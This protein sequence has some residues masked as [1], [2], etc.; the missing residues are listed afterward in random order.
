MEHALSESGHTQK[1]SK[2]T[3]NPVA[4]GPKSAAETPSRPKVPRSSHR[5][6]QTKRCKPKESKKADVNVVSVSSESPDKIKNVLDDD[7]HLSV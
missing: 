6:Y 3:K 5:K 1:S 7:I 4:K 2:P